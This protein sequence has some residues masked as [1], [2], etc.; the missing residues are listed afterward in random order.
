MRSD[1]SSQVQGISV[2]LNL[3]APKFPA[4]NPDPGFSESMAAVHREQS[5]PPRSEAADK[6]VKQQVRTTVKSE[7]APA[8]R[9]PLSQEVEGTETPVREAAVVVEDD[10]SE[11]VAANPDVSE[12]TI[13]HTQHYTGGM[14]TP[15]PMPL[16][17]P[18][19]PASHISLVPVAGSVAG[20]MTPTPS[21]E[22]APALS[23]QPGALN[24]T[25]TVETNGALITGVETGR[26]PVLQSLQ[27]G[28]VTL[29]PQDGSELAERAPMLPSWHSL[30]S[31][32]ANAG[33][34]VT[35]AAP[36]SEGQLA[37]ELVFTGKHDAAEIQ[38]P[39][40][41]TTST[42]GSEKSPLL[43]MNLLNPQA[44]PKADQ[45]FTRW[46]VEARAG[47]TSAVNPTSGA[48][49]G[50]GQRL[51]PQA[52]PARAGQRTALTVP[53]HQSN[54]GQ[55]VGE[56]ITWMVSQK[57]QF[58]EI[59]LD[60]PELGPLQVRISVQND[61]VS[62]SFTSQHA[63]VRDALD[64]HA[65]RLRDTLESQGLNLV[66]VDVSDQSEGWREQDQESSAASGGPDK[67]DDAAPVK[68]SV[69]PLSENRIDQFV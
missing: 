5:A 18:L 11:A 22:T 44:Q 49:A 3:G 39:L 13:P 17:T 53:F 43:T 56:K 59:Q 28:Q 54:W 51:Q 58:A 65:L 47:A 1:V 33:A 31:A 15:T 69:S 12:G 19:T 52:E 45:Q 27:Q 64:A 50:L 23:A 48:E 41:A 61:Q 67:E 25:A 46:N 40:S 55:G 14:S 9:A 34:P 21:G 63:P 4:R 38:R 16:Q 20:A 60:P 57:L 37:E 6:A 29:V 42:G 26:T 24:M 32:S 68:I 66:D 35:P 2:F 36:A 10:R 62:V 7:P 30:R 8:D